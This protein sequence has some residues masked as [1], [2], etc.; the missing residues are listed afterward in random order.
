MLTWSNLFAFGCL[1]KTRITQ[2]RFQ[3]RIN[4]EDI[5]IEDIDGE[6]AKAIYP[7]HKKLLPDKFLK[8]IS[9]VI[10]KIKKLLDDNSLDFPLLEGARFIPKKAKEEV[11]GMLREYKVQFDAAVED[12]IQSYEQA[13]REQ[14]PN[15]RKALEKY[16]ENKENSAEI[17]NQA[18]VR[19]EGSYPT[20]DYIRA[21]YNVTWRPMDISVPRDEETAEALEQQSQ[22]VK[23]AVTGMVDGLRKELLE[24]IT[25]VIAS[26]KKNE[27][28]QAKTLESVETLCNRV[29]NMNILNDIYIKSA[30]K[31]LRI[32]IRMEDTEQISNN[33]VSLKET[34]DSSA[35]QSR[36]AAINSLTKLGRR[37][38][39]LD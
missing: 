8:P 18:M 31:Q 26:A 3:T 33:M 15:I 11:K 19:I 12:L 1:I 32:I 37:G 28:I 20:P 21:K 6:F 5:G 36:D 10:Y 22:D 35:E 17:V 9:S 13:K 16:T 27:T 4:P 39:D 29:E 34:L 2:C 7:G 14:L 25:S 23:E 38:L 30:I 24:K